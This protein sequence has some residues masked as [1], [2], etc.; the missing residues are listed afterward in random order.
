MEIAKELPNFQTIEEVKEFISDPA[1]GGVVH[2][3]TQNG[4]NI[5]MTMN[6]F[7]EKVGIDNAAQFI[8][9]NAKKSMRF[10]ATMDEIDELM[11]KFENDPASLTK[12]EK[13]LLAMGV[14][15]KM[16]RFNDVSLSILTLI[17]KA[18]LD[19]KE[20]EPRIADFTGILSIVLTLLEGTLSLSSDKISIHCSTPTY[21]EM[22]R[23]VTEQIVIPEEVDEEVLLLSLIHIIG[24]RFITTKS[25]NKEVDFRKF[26]EVLGL[27]T[28]FLFEEEDNKS[29][30]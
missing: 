15:N 6:E 30:K 9:D 29:E 17:T 28:E 20:E 10:S 18:F 12:E 4:E 22:I 2:F 24:N 7:I 14:K 11:K 21:D 16:G 8:Y 13:I 25:I 5:T 23:A 26:A 1:N 3:V 19:F 27:D